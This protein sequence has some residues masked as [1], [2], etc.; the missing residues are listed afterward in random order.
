VAGQLET[1][2]VRTLTLN[3]PEWRGHLAGQH[4]D[5]RLTAPDGYQT[6]R[7]YSIASA[8]AAQQVQITVERLA[9]GEVSPYLVDEAMPEDHVEVRGPLGGY[10][11]WR[12]EMG[13]PVLLLG[14]GSGIVPLMSMLRHRAGMGAEVRFQLLYSC[15]TPEEVIY[16]EELAALKE[17]GLATAFTFT[18]ARAA[19]P[20]AFTRRIDRAMLSE[21]AGNEPGRDCVCLRALRIRGAGGE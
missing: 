7:S 11:V 19:A 8:P 15:R 16:R 12:A 4:I 18:R 9:D 1:P 6:A 5:V 2:R 3:V 13:G 21:V 10:F 17:R 20:G 14:G